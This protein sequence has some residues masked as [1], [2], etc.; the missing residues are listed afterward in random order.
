MCSRACIGSGVV[1]ARVRACA[2][3]CDAYAH[4]DTWCGDESWLAV[5]VCRLLPVPGCPWRTCRARLISVWKTCMPGSR[6]VA[7]LRPELL[8]LTRRLE[9]CGADTKTSAT[10]VVC[11]RSQART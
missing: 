9:A 11:E 10:G 2:A 7:L 8:S 6:N 1:R 3:A 4:M 5:L